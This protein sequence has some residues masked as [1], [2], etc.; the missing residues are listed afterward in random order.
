MNRLII[1]LAL[2]HMSLA[3]AQH[4]T[5]VMSRRPRVRLL[6]K[7]KE[8]YHRRVRDVENKGRHLAVCYTG[9]MRTFDHVWQSQRDNL[10]T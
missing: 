1:L 5:G 2:L 10:F 8:P 6:S 9:G 7:A 3:V 4:P